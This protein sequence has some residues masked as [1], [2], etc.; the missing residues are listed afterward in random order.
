D[1]YSNNFNDV[2]T[3]DFF[4][5]GFVMWNDGT[6]DGHINTNPIPYPSGGAVGTHVDLTYTLKSPI[7]VAA[8]D[9]T[10]IFDEIVLV[11]PGEDGAVWPSEDFYDYV[12][13]EGSVDGGLTWVPL[14]DGYDCSLYSEWKDL[15][16]SKNDGTNSTAVPTPALYRTHQFNLLDKFQAGDE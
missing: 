6:F 12:I 13:V 14:A 1:Y 3:S 8:I 9:A 4:G 2:S 11:E 10:V 15:W 16:N 5:T 7:R